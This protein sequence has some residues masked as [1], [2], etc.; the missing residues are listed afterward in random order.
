MGG[1]RNHDVAR[2][3]PS[4]S[5]G[6]AG[7]GPRA[8]R[9][10]KTPPHPPRRRQG[11]CIWKFPSRIRCLDQFGPLG[12]A[13]PRN[14]IENK[15]ESKWE[16]AAR[17][18]CDTPSEK[19]ANSALLSICNRPAED[20]EGEVT[21][22]IVVDRVSHHYRPPVGRPV[23]AVDDVSLEV[24]TRVPGV[25]RAVGLRQVDLLY[26][27][28]GFLPTETGL[29]HRRRQAGQPGPGRTAASCSSTSRCFRGRRYAPTCM[30]GLKRQGLPRAEAGKAGPGLHRSRRPARV[31][32]QLSLAALRRHE[33]AHRDR[34]HA[35][36]RSAKC[37]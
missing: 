30:Y 32:G 19:P 21:A 15:P 22:E 4:P 11:D 14:R 24:A 33:A 2:S 36:D 6:R 26:L 31:R 16:P 18:S 8:Q 29:D 10:S 3:Y 7:W 5:S 23:L 1:A 37:C 25:A 20:G 34:A 35:R 27:L 9:A 13:N 28:G 12:S 17:S